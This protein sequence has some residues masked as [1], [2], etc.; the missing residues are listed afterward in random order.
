[1]QFSKKYAELRAQFNPDVE[2]TDFSGSEISCH[3]FPFH[4][5]YPGDYLKGLKI[6]DSVTDEIFMIP[7]EEISENQSFTYYIFTSDL[8]NRYD[9]AILL[10]HGLNERSW[11]KYLSWAYYLAEN[12]GYPVILFPI[13]FHMNRSPEA[14]GNPRI[15]QPLHDLRN[16]QYGVDPASSF[17]NVALSERLTNDPLR[18]FTSGQQS[19]ADL[20]NLCR[21]INRG[22]HPSFDIGATVNVFAYSIGAF[23]AQILFLANPEKL[24]SNSKLFLFCGGAFFNEMNGV[25][26]LIMDEVAFTRLR[27]FYI[28]ELNQEFNGPESLLDSMKKTEMGQ[29][30]LAMLAPG[31]MQS[32]RETRFGELSDRIQTIALAKDQVI[33]ANKI[34]TTLGN[35]IAVEIFD[36]PFSYSHETPFPLHNKLLFPLVD[37]G[38]EKIFS[39]TAGFL[40]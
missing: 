21:Q 27:S 26:K 40:K 25:S 11:I 17:A 30:F 1:M 10:L 14:W 39:K 8:K 28:D 23:L 19:A 18:F 24:F 6:Q 22:E 2:R 7:D 35:G 29:A 12:T 3:S 37:D 5:S 9:K 13:A 33:P 15:M 4:S 38:F 32:F 31:L 16:K 36:F 20:V 34:S